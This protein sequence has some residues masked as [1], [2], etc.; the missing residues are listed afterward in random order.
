MATYEEIQQQKPVIDKISDFFTKQSVA[1]K[2]GLGIICVILGFLYNNLDIKEKIKRNRKEFQRFLNSFNK[3]LNSAA[4]RDYIKDVDKMCLDYM[5][6]LKLVQ[7][8]HAYD[9]DLNLN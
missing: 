1:F 8:E 5:A 4:L 9:V 2:I 7:L 6:F 3:Y